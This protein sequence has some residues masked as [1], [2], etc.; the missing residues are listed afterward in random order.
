VLW[1]GAECAD[2]DLDVF[3]P[4]A[5]G[6]GLLPDYSAALAVCRRCEAVVDCRSYADRQRIVDGVWGG[7]TPEQREAERKARRAA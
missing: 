4:A 6:R 3:F 5:P 7:R 1:E 2:A